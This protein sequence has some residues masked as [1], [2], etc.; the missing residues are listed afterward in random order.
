[1]GEDGNTSALKSGEPTLLPR[2]ATAHLP[3]KGKQEYGNRSDSN[4]QE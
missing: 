1:L 4:R 2:A 3:A